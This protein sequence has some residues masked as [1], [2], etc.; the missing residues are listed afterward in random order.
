MGPQEGQAE[1]RD[2]LDRDAGWLRKRRS[3]LGPADPP[4]R[5]RRLALHTVAGALTGRTSSW[6]HPRSGL[7]ETRVQV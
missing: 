2:G 6:P 1:S 3:P 5:T 4:P 7:M